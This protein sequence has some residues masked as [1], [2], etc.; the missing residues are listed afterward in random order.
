MRTIIL[1]M[2]GAFLS[3]SFITNKKETLSIQQLIKNPDFEVTVKSNGKHSGK[4]VLLAIKSKSLKDV[5]LRVPAG[6]LFYPSDEKEQTL[7]TPR[8]QIMAI[9][10]KQT[11]DVGVYGFCTEANDKS[12]TSSGAFKVGTNKNEKLAQLLEFFKENKGIRVHAVQEA[13]WCVTDNESISHAYSDDPVLDKKLK[14]KL[15]EITGQKIPW[16]TNKRKITTNNRGY[17]VA[18]P[19]EVVGEVTFSTTQKTVVKSK[20]INEAGV[21]VFPNTNELKIPQAIKNIKLDF[22]V[23]VTGW[24]KGKYYVIYY[25][26]EGKT[27]LKKEFT[28]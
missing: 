18:S 28:V 2:I 6:A 16:H 25:T 4:S 22:K 7:I 9:N 19:V 3:L 26:G 5:S 17:I 14:K 12:P 11:N 8:E 21:V 13:I 15:S 27:I 10:K 24:D 1:I 20:V 23:K